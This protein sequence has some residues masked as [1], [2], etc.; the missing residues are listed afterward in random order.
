MSSLSTNLQPMQNLANIGWPPSLPIELA[1]GVMEPLAL[2]HHYDI[3]DETW[4]ALPK[5]PSFTAAVQNAI[6]QLKADGA[7]FKMRARL[8][9]EANLHTTQDLIN[10]AQT[11]ATVRQNLI[12]AM[13]R[14]AGYDAKVDA[15]G[16]VAAAQ[17]A[18]FQ[19]NILMSQG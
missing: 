5:N 15:S 9:A 3:D 1:L 18:A 17:G 2:K 4:N 14:W 10:N 13:A 6:D 19:I 16:N 7:G 8:L 12:V 11:P